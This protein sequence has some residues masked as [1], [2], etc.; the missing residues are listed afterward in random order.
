MDKEIR[1]RL[2]QLAR[3]KTTCTYSRLNEQLQLRLNFKYASDRKLLG[4]WL[5]EVSRHEFDR[6]R[7]I[8]SSLIIYQGIER[9]QGIGFYKLCEILY[10]KSWRKFRSN[11]NLV[12]EIM[13]ECYLFWEDD[14]NYRKYK[15][16]H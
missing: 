9:D 12:I 8:L 4:Q 11:K 13:N 10:G 5:D 6:K 7:P 15:F 16:D 2:I 14:E 3:S 1:A